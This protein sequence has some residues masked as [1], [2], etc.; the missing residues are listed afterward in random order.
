[1]GF[2]SLD[3]QWLA[4]GVAGIT[5]QLGA[6]SLESHINRRRRAVKH[7]PLQNNIIILLN[8]K[9]QQIINI[10]ISRNYDI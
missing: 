2:A 5:S 4:G 8:T 6:T 1:M 7:V 9:I 3:T 10:L